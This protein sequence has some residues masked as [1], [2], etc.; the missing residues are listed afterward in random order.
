MK[1][2]KKAKKFA[3]NTKVCACCDCSSGDADSCGFGE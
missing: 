1:L 2:L 3:S